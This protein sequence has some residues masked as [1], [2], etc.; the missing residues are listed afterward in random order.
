MALSVLVALAREGVTRVVRRALPYAS[1]VAGALLLVAGAYLFYYWSRLHF[2][3]T[4][5][6]ADDP[7][8]SFGVRFSGRVR[9]FADGRGSTMV[10]VAGAI[11]AVAIV[12]GLWKRRRRILGRSLARE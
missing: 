9:G 3:D 7:V 6:V 10:A 11:V 8:V 4:A 2:G 12:T 1:R 5:T